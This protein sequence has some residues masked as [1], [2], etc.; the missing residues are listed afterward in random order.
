MAPRENGST[1]RLVLEENDLLLRILR[2]LRIWIWRNPIAGRSLV[3]SFV[4]EGR[5][6]AKTSEGRNWQKRLSG[7]ATVQRGRLLW[8]AYGLDKLV[9]GE[10]KLIPSEWLELLTEALAQADLEETLSTLMLDEAQ[11][12]TIDTA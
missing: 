1:P 10:P 9:E 7:S 6:F 3:Q 11:H 8:Q 12:A 5:R 4:A 2:Q